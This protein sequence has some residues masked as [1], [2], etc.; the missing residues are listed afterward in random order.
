MSVHKKLMQICN[1]R[2]LNGYLDMLHDDFTLV[3]HKLGNSFLS[4]SAAYIIQ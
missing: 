3:F 1:D 2:Y 4:S